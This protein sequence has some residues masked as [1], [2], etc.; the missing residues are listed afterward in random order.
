MIS[1]RTTALPTQHSSTLLRHTRR[2][3]TPHLAQLVHPH[4]LLLQIQPTLHPAL[5][6]IH[7]P[8][9]RHRKH[10]QREEEHEWHVGVARA[11]DDGGR[12]KGTDKGGCLADDGEEGKEEELYGLALAA[13]HG[14]GD[15]LY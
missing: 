15:D 2:T 7:T 6:Y 1:V 3:T 12:D 13:A 11:L 10:A 4:R 8:Q 5:V 14:E 9:D